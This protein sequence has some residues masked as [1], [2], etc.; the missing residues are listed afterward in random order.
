MRLTEKIAY[1]KGLLEGME[2]D[3]S[4]KEGKAISKIADVMEDMAVYIDDL[5][6]QVDELTE[7]CDILDEDLGSVESDLYE[8]EDEDEDDY[9]DEDDDDDYDYDRHFPIGSVLSS[10]NLYDDDLSDAD[11]DDDDADDDD[12]YDTQY[13]VTCTGCGQTVPLDEDQLAE[14]SIECPFCGEMLEFNYDTV[15]ADI[16]DDESE[17]DQSEEDEPETGKDGSDE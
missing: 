7:L 8:D 4:T 10:R 9:D 11:I 14:G 5:Q 3:T 12:D 17:D 16:S 2:L 6:S 1:L 13:I 15:E